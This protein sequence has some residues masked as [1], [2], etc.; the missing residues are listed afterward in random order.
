MTVFLGNAPSEIST[1]LE[2][3]GGLIHP[4]NGYTLFYE[5][6]LTGSVDLMRQY[7]GYSPEA[8]LFYDYLT[9]EEHI[10]LCCMVTHS[11]SIVHFSLT[12]PD[13]CWFFLVSR[14]R[15]PDYETSVHGPH[16]PPPLI[17]SQKAQSQGIVRSAEAEAVNGHGT[18][19]QSQSSH[20]GPPDG[21]YGLLR[22]TRNLDH[23]SSKLAQKTGKIGLKYSNMSTCCGGW[24]AGI[25]EEADDHCHGPY[26][27]RR[28]LVCG[29]D[30]D[31]G[32]WAPPLILIS[33]LPYS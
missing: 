2:C 21:R 22:G 13:L 23:P 1:L 28:L 30:W 20:P 4:T 6:L 27:G 12:S 24:L 32:Q 17:P 5:T 8:H 26:T 31:P 15:V 16:D 3:L 18:G 29:A 10:Q 19:K 25:E 33:E 7:V 9:V 11:F 14:K